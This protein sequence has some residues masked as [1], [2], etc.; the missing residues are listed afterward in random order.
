MTPGSNPSWI[1][2]FFIISAINISLIRGARTVHRGVAMPAQR[3]RPPGRGIFFWKSQRLAWAARLFTPWRL[4]ADQHEASAIFWEFVTE[5]NDVGFSVNFQQ[6]SHKY[7]EC[8]S[9]ELLP[10]VL[11]DYS[12]DFVLGRYPYQVP[13]TYYLHFDNSHSTDSTSIV[14]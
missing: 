3:H 9:R 5:T 8:S 4:G 1:P 11:R 13:G 10:V 6:S 2:D 14:Y 7:R 12:E